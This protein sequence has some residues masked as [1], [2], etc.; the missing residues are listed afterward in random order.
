MNFIQSIYAGVII[1]LLQIKIL[2]LF[3]LVSVTLGNKLIVSE[4][5]IIGNEI[6][7]QYVI[8]REIQHQKN[9]FLDST[10]AGEDRNRIENLGIFSMVSWQGLPL[11]NGTVILQFVVLESWRYLPGLIPFYEE[12][13]G[14][15]VS[16]GLI[17]NNFRG[18]NQTLALGGEF[19]GRT[20]YGLQYSDPWMAGDHIS[21]DFALGNSAQF[22]LFLPYEI[23]T[24]SFQLNTG[25]Y[26]GYAIK[27]KAGFELE[28][29]SFM[30]LNGSSN[31]HFEYIAPKVNIQY[32][33]RDLYSDPSSGIYIIQDFNY[34]IDLTGEENNRLFWYQSYSIFKTIFK[35]K[36]KV[37]AGFNFFGREF[38]GSERDTVW[39]Q[40]IG[41]AYSIRGWNTP[42]EEI[43]SGGEQK[44]RFGL[45]TLGSSFE[46]RKTIIPRI[47][48]KYGTEFGLSAVGFIDGGITGM[49][50]SEMMA[51]KPIWGI[52]IGIRIPMAIFQV[53]RFDDGWGFRGSNFVGNSF[54]F[55]FGHKF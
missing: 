8:Q 31:H 41:G 42:T 15:I 52:G 50:L 24:S 49:S 20:A 3:F 14:W 1:Y 48:T 18:R 40:S 43:Y 53:I 10:L 51:Q 30:A 16:G 25:R 54:H 9:V 44:Y 46:L 55:A 39:Y 23:T 7:K 34:M 28:K 17:I 13:K 12:G 26:F 5:Q 45:F 6:T 22:H 37:V 33:T 11:E 4:I 27:T 2:P 47:A 21:L 35:G 29:K 19:G 36:R 32:D 38:F